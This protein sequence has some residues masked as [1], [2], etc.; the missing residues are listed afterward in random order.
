MVDVTG[1]AIDVVVV[2]YNTRELTLRCVDCL[3]AS[4][5]VKLDLVVVDNGSSDGT[6]DALAHLSP[7]VRVIPLTN[8]VGFG[9]ANNIGFT[10]GSAPYVALINSDAFVEPDTLF[11]LVE[12]MGSCPRAGVVGPRILNVDGSVQKSCFYFPTPRRAWLENTGVGWLLDKLAPVVNVLRRGAIGGHPVEWLSG[13][14]L[15]VRREVIAHVGGFDERFFLYSE[16]TDWQYRIRQS[17]WQILWL[18]EAKLVHLG[19]GTGG[20]GGA[21]RVRECFFESVDRYFRKHYGLLGV[22]QLRAATALGAGIR[23]FA[24]CLFRKGSTAQVSY[25]WLLRRQLTK[26]FSS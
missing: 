25:T 24:G 18:P 13:A 4:R 11:Q 20:G 23:L 15:V 6:L 17:G 7:K 2:S 16:E 22:L 3:L 8:N 26:G 10:K 12:Y 5:N 21:A 19:G 14:A 9:G 1:E